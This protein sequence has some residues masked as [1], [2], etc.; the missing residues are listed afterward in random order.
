MR[1][2]RLLPI[3]GV[4]IIMAA[5]GEP[6]LRSRA[7]GGDAQA[8]FEF[9]HKCGYSS[10]GSL[11]NPTEAIKWYLKSAE[12]GH[13]GAQF[14]LARIYAYG[15]GVPR[16]E[17]EAAKWFL[18]ADRGDAQYQ[19]ELGLNYQLG[20][21]VSKNL[22][23][24]AKWYRKAADQGH[25]WAQEYLADIYFDWDDYAE[26]GKWYRKAADQ[27]NENAQIKLVKI[28]S[29]G[30]GVSV[31]LV[32]AYAWRNL[33]AVSFAWP[34]AERVEMEKMMTREEIIRA[35]QRSTELHKEIEARK[36]A[37]K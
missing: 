6:D 32:E 12:Q 20:D 23:E 21:G 34:E 27:G 25:R 36:K 8:Q 9:G 10:D 33:A 37:G 15:R 11:I 35:Q 22:S 1:I 18:K 24:A 28:Y 2:L 31:D 5:C 13:L 30:M 14:E 7:E 4:A 17:A 3:C 16:N 29:R 19:Y 26:A